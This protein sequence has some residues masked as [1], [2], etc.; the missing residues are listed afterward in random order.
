MPK[1]RIAY[2]RQKFEANQ[3]RDMASVSALE[4]MGWKVMVI[5]ECEASVRNSGDLLKRLMNFLDEE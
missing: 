5:W 4:E 2:W 3:N 1:T